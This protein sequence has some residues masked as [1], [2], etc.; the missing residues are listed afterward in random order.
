MLTLRRLMIS[1]MPSTSIPSNQDGTSLTTTEQFW[2][3][4]ILSIKYQHI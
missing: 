3:M 4:S 2:V 1:K